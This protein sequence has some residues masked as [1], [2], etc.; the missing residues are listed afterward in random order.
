MGKAETQHQTE[1]QTPRFERG[2]ERVHVVLPQSWKSRTDLTDY[3]SGVPAADASHPSKC[4]IPSRPASHRT[5]QQTEEFETGAVRSMAFPHD[6]LLN[7]M[8]VS[9]RSARASDVT[10]RVHGVFQLASAPLVRAVALRP[11][12]DY[13]FV[14]SL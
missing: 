2:E 1:H 7:D 8:A 13:R 12:E 9:I 3:D 4:P 14:G 10:L 6:S 11:S 5:P